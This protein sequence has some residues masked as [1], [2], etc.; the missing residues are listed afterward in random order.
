MEFLDI[1]VGNEVNTIKF[2]KG[3]NIFSIID[4]ISILGHAET[5]EYLFLEIKL[6]SLSG[7]SFSNSVSASINNIKF[8]LAYLDITATYRVLIKFWNYSYK[9]YDMKYWMHYKFNF[10]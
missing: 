1:N 6:T 4:F 9:K 5:I 8:D 3:I 7:P 2:N 10:R